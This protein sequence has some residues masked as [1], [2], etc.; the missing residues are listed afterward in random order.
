MGKLL[1]RTNGTTD[2]QTWS[3]Q[4]AL[5]TYNI[6]NWGK[7]YFGINAAGHVIV[8]PSKDTAQSLDIKC[9]VAFACRNTARA[10]FA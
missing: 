4:D 10:A 9:A 6:A 2:G 5:D 1:D 3:Q 8:H 7:G